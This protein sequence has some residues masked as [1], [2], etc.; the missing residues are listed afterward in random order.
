V[1]MVSKHQ[2]YIWPQHGTRQH[3]RKLL[4]TASATFINPSKT[5]LM[6]ETILKMTGTNSIKYIILI[7]RIC[8]GTS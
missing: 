8:P 1:V 2:I 7:S 4:S 6:L 5:V 3:S